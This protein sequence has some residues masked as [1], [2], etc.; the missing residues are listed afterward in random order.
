VPA[1]TAPSEK[2]E[3]EAA[4]TAFDWIKD[5]ND[6]VLR[7]QPETA[8]YFNPHGAIVIRQR[9]WPDDDMVVVINPECINR[10]ID[11]LT[12]IVGGRSL[13]R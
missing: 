3:P 6:V 9:S 8:I 11:K 1:V 10:F 12:D 7:S 2:D 5:D 4:G 13:G